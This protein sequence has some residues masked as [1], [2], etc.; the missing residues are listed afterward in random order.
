[1]NRRSLLIRT[2]VIAGALG[3]GWWLKENVLWSAPDLSFA[4]GT[5]TPW[6]DFAAR[7]LSPTIPV[8]IAGR[9]VNALIDSGAQYSVIDRDFHTA[10]EAELGPRPLFDIPLVAYGVGGSIGSLASGWLWDAV[11]P[12]ATFLSAAVVALL[13]FWLGWRR[14]PS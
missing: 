12:E 9:T 6:I 13:G 2:G 7:V 14:L 8:R 11:S 1:M 10:I 5:T 3:G 4:E